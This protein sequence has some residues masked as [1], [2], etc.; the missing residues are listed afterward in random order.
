MESILCLALPS[1]C[2]ARLACRQDGEAVREAR[3]SCHEHDAEQ[4]PD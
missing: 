2:V 3:P 4:L 1:C